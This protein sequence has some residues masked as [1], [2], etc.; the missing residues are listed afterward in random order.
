MV[1]LSAPKVIT[2]G[3]H[4]KAMCNITFSRDGDWQLGNNFF[5]LGKLPFGVLPT[6]TQPLNFNN[7]T[8]VSLR[9]TWVCFRK[10]A[11]VIVVQKLL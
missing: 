1:G 3:Q 9:M 11:A 8:A 7:C 2:P 10:S 4:F 6:L 5:S